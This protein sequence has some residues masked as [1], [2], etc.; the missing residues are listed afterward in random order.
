MIVIVFFAGFVA[1]SPDYSGNCKNPQSGEQS[2]IS[3]ASQSQ[4]SITSR[5]NEADC[6]SPKWYAAF[7]RPDG[8]L[9]I[10]GIITFVIIGWQSWETRRAANS[11][12]ESMEAIVQS[13]RAWVFA[14]IGQLP[15]IEH[16]EDEVGLAIMPILF[17]NYG[18]TPAR[19]IRLC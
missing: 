16:R 9:V 4:N 7:K 17:R 1:G 5:T 13:E 11:A 15:N 3:S 18:R 8:M 6:H 12:A 14:D 19:L 10:V 2:P